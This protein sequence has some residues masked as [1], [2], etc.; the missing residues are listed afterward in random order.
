MQ[1]SNFFIR[2]LRIPNF[3]KRFQNSLKNEKFIKNPSSDFW[4]NLERKLICDNE[5]CTFRAHADPKTWKIWWSTILRSQTG[6]EIQKTYWPFWYF[7]FPLGPFWHHQSI[8]RDLSCSEHFFWLPGGSYSVPNDHFCFLS[9][10]GRQQKN[11]ENAKINLRNAKK[12]FW[13]LKKKFRKRKK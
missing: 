5:I 13:R 11:L 3:L 10:F 9:I 2:F 1:I 7:S 4:S 12:Q 6:P 8:D